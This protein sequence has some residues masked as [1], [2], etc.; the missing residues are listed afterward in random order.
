MKPRW[1]LKAP[2]PKDQP[3]PV[4]MEALEHSYPK[5]GWGHF[6]DMGLGK[7]CVALNEFL[8]FVE[9]FQFMRM[10]IIA[11]NNFKDDWLA[12]AIEFGFP[13]DMMVLDS[14]DRKSV[15]RW[16]AK[17]RDKPLALV[18][19]YESARTVDTQSLITEFIAGFRAYTTFDESILAKGHDGENFKA[20]EKISKQSTAKRLLSGKPISQGSHDLWA[21]LKLIG[22]LEK[23]NFYAFRNRYCIMGGFKNKQVVAEKNSEELTAYL[24]NW[25]FFALSKDYRTWPDPTWTTRQVPMPPEQQ[26]IYK[27]MEHDFM[28]DLGEGRVASAEAIITRLN[29]LQQI[30]S[31]FMY[32]DEGNTHI[33][34][35]PNKNPRIKAIKDLLNNEINGKLIIGAFHTAAI[36]MLV[37]ELAEF[38]VVW[39]VGKERMEPG[40]LIEHKRIFNEDDN[41]R[42]LVGQLVATKYGHT[43]LGSR[44][45]PC[46]HTAFFENT[47][48]LDTR[49]QFEKRNER[50]GQIM[51]VQYI[52]FIQ[53]PM[54]RRV[55][56][57]LQRKEDVASAVLGYARE[58]GILKGVT[59]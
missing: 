1:L 48:S 37:K 27:E 33:L 21:Q 16:M 41:C 23:K 39:I 14:D 56:G 9:D 40:Q 12:M 31:G 35:P 3:L 7:T 24:K 36:D 46:H 45:M 38:G 51:G 28:V 53:S 13:F 19:N 29:K 8:M 2:P 57:A 22:A 25:S 32:D 49:S 52:D 10:P 20:C 17:N 5:A 4:Q 6:L 55:V 47:F 26:K 18:V 11:P 59:V 42:G 50:Q 15:R 44:I 34:I 54:D 58:L 43:L 30:T